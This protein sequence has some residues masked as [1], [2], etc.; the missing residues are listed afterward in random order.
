MNYLILT[1]SLLTAPDLHYTN[2]AQEIVDR[3]IAAHGF[4]RLDHAYVQFEFRNRLY[5]YRNENGLFTYTR[6]F[7]DEGRQITDILN[8]DGLVREVEGREAGI[9]DERRAAYGRS[10]NSVIYFAFLPY[11][12]NDP[13]VIKEYLGQVDIHGTTYDKV[14]VTFHQEGG[15]RD[16]E[17][18][19]YFWFDASTYLLDYFAYSFETDGGGYR[20]RSFTNR[21]KVRGMVIQDYQNYKPAEEN[22]DFSRI[23]ELFMAGELV[24]LSQINLEQVRVKP[25]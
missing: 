10:V 23:E 11:R 12:L 19:F 6:T 14:K 24:V 4:D 7:E 13:A 25:L 16:Y 2:P 22:I 21:R 5:T 15:G 20:F 8:N 1:L 9:T 3:S 18:V 17:D